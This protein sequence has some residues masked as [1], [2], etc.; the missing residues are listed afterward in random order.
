MQIM[1]PSTHVALFR[2]THYYPWNFWN[3][4]NWFPDRDG[5]AMHS[6]DDD[7]WMT[8]DKVL[9]PQERIDIWDFFDLESSFLAPPF[10]Q[11]IILNL[12]FETM[13]TR[14][15]NYVQNDPTLDIKYIGEGTKQ[16]LYCSRALT[17]TEKLELRDLWVSMITVVNA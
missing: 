8:T 10:A 6:R 2:T 14:I 7:L 17:N 12:D 16:I 9:T 13:K 11:K 4:F 5:S 15:R 1:L 3:E